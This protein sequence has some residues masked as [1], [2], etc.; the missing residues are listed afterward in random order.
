MTVTNIH[1]HKS[2]DGTWICFKSKDGQAAFN[3]GNM[4]PDGAVRRHVIAQWAEE[5]MERAAQDPDVTA[6][7]EAAEELVDYEAATGLRC[8][9]KQEEAVRTAIEGGVD[10]HK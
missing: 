7:L 4:F 9:A 3:I 5:Q 10:E 2:E 6:L 8:T 1:I